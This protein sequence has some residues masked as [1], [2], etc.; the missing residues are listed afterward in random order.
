MKHARPFPVPHFHCG[1]AASAV[2]PWYALRKLSALE[3]GILCNKLRSCP[4]EIDCTMGGNIFCQPAETDSGAVR[5]FPGSAPVPACVPVP[6]AVH[7]PRCAEA[8][9]GQ[10]LHSGGPWNPWSLSERGSRPRGARARGGGDNAW[11]SG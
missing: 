2:V 1:G 4:A 3:C 6:A 11:C 5:A 9:G 7:C 10:F 8:A